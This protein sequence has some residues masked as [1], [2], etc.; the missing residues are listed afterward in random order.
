MSS[1]EQKDVALIEL[2]GKRPAEWF[3]GEKVSFGQRP[4]SMKQLH[5]PH[6]TIPSSLASCTALRPSTRTQRQT[7]F[8][9]SLNCAA[10]PSLC[11]YGSCTQTLN[12]AD[13]H[14]GVNAEL[15]AVVHTD[16]TFLFETLAS[17]HARPKKCIF[18]IKKGWL[19]SLPLYFPKSIINLYP[20]TQIK[21]NPWFLLSYFSHFNLFQTSKQAVDVFTGHWR[22]RDITCSMWQ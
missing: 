16:I 9:S 19:T 11:L 5:K 4:V 7:I 15:W 6:L 2:P 8:R 22:R 17:N 21:T 10:R 18:M 3:R 12:E 1:Y 13:Q 20:S 14:P